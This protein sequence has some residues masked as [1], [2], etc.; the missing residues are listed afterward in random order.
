MIFQVNISIFIAGNGLAV[1]FPSFKGLQMAFHHCKQL[2]L[3]DYLY[4]ALIQ[5]L[6]TCPL[7]FLNGYQCF[8]HF[9][10]AI[11]FYNSLS[12]A[13]MAAIFSMLIFATTLGLKLQISSI[14]TIIV[15]QYSKPAD[16]SKNKHQSSS[17]H[18]HTLMQLAL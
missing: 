5:R 11:L 17:M 10:A 6:P 2:L 16:Q 12:L 14:L 18:Q 4:P 8:L 1:H 13:T 3:A 7:F 9:L 15:D